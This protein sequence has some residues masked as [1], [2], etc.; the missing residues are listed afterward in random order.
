VSSVKELPNIYKETNMSR[1]LAMP[2]KMLEAVVRL[3]SL[4]KD[5][6]SLRKYKIPQA[7][8]SFLLNMLKYAIIELEN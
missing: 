6:K 7:F 4:L 8:L 5:K 2:H 3:L 1:V